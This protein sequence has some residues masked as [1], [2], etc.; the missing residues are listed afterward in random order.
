LDVKRLLHRDKKV[1]GVLAYDRAAVTV[2]ED[3]DDFHVGL[4]PDYIRL[5][6]GVSIRLSGG[7]LSL[8]R[9]AMPGPEPLARPT[10]QYG[11]LYD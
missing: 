9:N 11:V 4:Q 3:R 5:P 6:L 10:G 7:A 8:D 2:A 1:K